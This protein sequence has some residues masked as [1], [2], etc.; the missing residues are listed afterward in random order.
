M[1]IETEA[2]L[3]NGVGTPLLYLFESYKCCFGSMQ[4]L[5]GGN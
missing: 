1:T 5:G 4:V 2:P 3:S